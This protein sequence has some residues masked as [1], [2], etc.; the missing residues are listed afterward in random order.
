V[1]GETD[2]SALGRT[3][4]ATRSIQNVVRSNA[5]DIV[6][7]VVK[8]WTEGVNKPQMYQLIVSGVQNEELAALEQF[9][10]TMPDVVKVYRRSFNQE[11]AEL[12]LEFKGLQS[13]LVHGIEKNKSV[14]LRLVGDE[15]LRISFEKKRSKK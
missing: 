12:E 13:S 8:H 6:F 1:P 4:A 7:Q 2:T 3:D 9:L 14:Q 11:V 5:K 10:S 15:P